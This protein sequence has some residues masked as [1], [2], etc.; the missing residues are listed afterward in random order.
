VIT[1]DLPRTDIERLHLT[2]MSQLDIRAALVLQEYL[3]WLATVRGTEPVDVAEDFGAVLF[4][5]S[6]DDPSND[7]SW[8]EYQ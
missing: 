8:T 6:L 5:R 3:L 4:E 7:P 2:D 1:N